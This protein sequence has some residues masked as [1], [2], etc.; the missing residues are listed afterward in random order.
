M[1]T[2]ILIVEDETSEAEDIKRVLESLDYEVSH[3]A[4]YGEVTE[5]I[6]LNIMPDLILIDLQLNGKNEGIEA[7]ARIKELNIPVV[8][9]TTYQN[10]L[11]INRIHSTDPY[12]YIIKPFEKKR[13]K[14][15][16][17]IGTV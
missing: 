5:E 9:L 7:A 1:T 10:E 14:I 8:Y 13:I 12:G 4:S 3:I 15:Y 2:K 11:D 17:R 16:N 6:A